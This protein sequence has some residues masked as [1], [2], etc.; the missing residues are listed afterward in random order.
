MSVTRPKPAR[1]LTL[2]AA[3]V[4]RN[5]RS[6]RVSFFSVPR[7]S[8]LVAFLVS[9]GLHGAAGMWVKVRSVEVV[10]RPETA[11]D[12]WSGH[13][14]AIEEAEVDVAP[15]TGSAPASA[16]DEPATNA[17]DPQDHAVALEP[18]CGVDC[19][20][21]AKK[22]TPV[23]AERITQAL[24]KPTATS[25]KAT[26]PSAESTAAAPS[27]SM[28]T[29]TGTMS[30]EA[31]GAVGL[32]PGVRYLPKAYTR[33]LNQGSWG[34]RGFATVAAGKLCDARF[35]IAVGADR[36]LGDIE[37]PDES[38]RDAVPPLCRTM[39]ENGL[40]LV[41]GGEFSLDP[42]TL[43]AGTMRLRVR[44]EISE[45]APPPNCD[46]DPSKMCSESQETP[47]PGRRGRSTFI[48]N[49]GR[50][51]DAFIDLE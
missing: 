4:T 3:K 31:F 43:D 23:E 13:G 28:T 29:S 6:L 40:L 9:L 34:V 5:Y 30:G 24:P 2:R 25:A 10:P 7:S 39:F 22:P 8:V 45:G 12:V 41:R 18:V 20:P 49:S 37:Y 15:S 19:T 36:R 26:T 1:Q 47:A 21:V 14:I 33:A 42:K 44:V 50:R 16:S 35:A 27:S 38:A 17:S 48:L 11:P 51:V 32:P 46:G